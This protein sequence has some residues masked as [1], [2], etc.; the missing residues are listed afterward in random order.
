MLPATALA[1]GVLAALLAWPVPAALARARWPRRDPLAA[2]VCWQA[3]GLAGG[4][5]IIG[6]LLVHGLAPWGHSLPEAWWHWVTW[7]PSTEPVRG[8]HWVAQT[9]AAVL[10]VELLGVL[11][12]S[13]VRTARTR[14]RHRAL[15]ELLVRPGES[16]AEET[17]LLDHPAPVAF[18]IPGARPLLVLSSGMVAELDGAQLD[19]V[20]AHERAHLREHHHL[21]LLPFVAWRAALPVLPAADRAHD[22]VRDLVEMRADD[23]ALRSL[24]GPDPRRTLA[25]AIVAA[26]GGAGGQVPDGALAVTGGP[27]AVRVR[28]LLAP[29]DPLPARARWAALSSAVA[30][31]F[32]PTL[33]LL[34]P[35][36]V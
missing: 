36:V 3:I 23:V 17:L 21:L 25:V 11:A 32:V 7:Q 5:S 35:A 24:S 29:A 13:G 12:L 34:L 14:R 2:L 15:L 10:A 26:A 31:L 4:L 6:A 30:L 27:V 1:L 16:A 22:G 18:C 28:R 19:A 9:L 8:D 33:L 20:V